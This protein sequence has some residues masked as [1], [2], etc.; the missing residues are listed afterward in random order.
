MQVPVWGVAGGELVTAEC[1][2]RGPA[3][4]TV[5]AARVGAPRISLGCPVLREST[6]GPTYSEVRR[7]KA[8]HGSGAPTTGGCASVSERLGPLYKHCSPYSPQFPIHGRHLS[9]IFT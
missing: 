7:M 1:I 2:L 8:Q 4:S 9:G 6:A 3:V 5:M